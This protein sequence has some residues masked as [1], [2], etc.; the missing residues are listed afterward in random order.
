M[1]V[2]IF[3]KGI[4]SEKRV[5]VHIIGKMYSL[6]VLVSGN[7]PKQSI[8]ILL[9]GLLAVPRQHFN[10]GSSWLFFNQGKTKGEGRS[11]AK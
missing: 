1:F 9:K 11:T 8:M 3:L 7:G 5:E 4:A 10:F 2:V 6:P